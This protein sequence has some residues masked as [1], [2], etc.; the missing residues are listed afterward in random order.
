MS[1]SARLKYT[2]ARCSSEDP[3]YPVSE[4]LTHSPDT[5]GWQSARFCDFPQEL[6]LQF[7]TP[8]HLRQ[9]QFLSHQSKIAT[10]IE[11]FTALPSPGQNWRYDTA[12]FKRL[13]YF[14]LD[15]NERS[16]FQA[17]ELKSVY[18][19]VSVQFLRIL[20][21]K[22]HVNRFNIVNQVGL[23]AV[24]CLG[25]ALG[26]DLAVGPPAP[27]PVLAQRDGAPQHDGRGALGA[28]KP[29]A[30]PPAISAAES[31]EDAAQAAA[32]EMQFDARTVERLRALE[33]A[34]QRAVELEDYDEAKRLK[35]MLNKLRRTGQLIRELEERK[36]AAVQNEDFDAAKSLKVEIDRL[37]AGVD[38]P[39]Q[40]GSPSPPASAAGMPT[41]ASDGRETPS[42]HL[43]AGQDSPVGHQ[44]SAHSSLGIDR[45]PRGSRQPT[46]ATAMPSN[47]SDGEGVS[48]QGPGP[49]GRASPRA[50]FPGAP[51]SPAK[52]QGSED[53]GYVSDFRKEASNGSQQVHQPAEARPTDSMGYPSSADARAALRSKLG[54]PAEVD[55]G[56]RPRSSG[57]RASAGVPRDRGHPL[58]GVPNVD[59]LPSPEE[60]GP[61]VDKAADEIKAMFGEY[62]ARCIFSKTWNLRDAAL[63]K[64]A[65]DLRQGEHDEENV[66]ELLGAY[67]A[68]LKISLLDKNVQVFLASA[69]LLQAVCQQ[70]CDKWRSRNAEAQAALDPLLRL[71]VERLGDA[72]AR[73][74]KTTRDALLEFGRCP[75]LTTPFVAQHLLR[76]LKKKN[77]HSRVYT[78]RLQLLTALVTEAGVQPEQREG[79]PLEPTVQLAMEWFAS[80]QADVREGSVKLVAACFRHV[81]LPRIEKHLASL[82]AAQR[83]VFDIEFDKVSAA[84]ADKSELSKPASYSPPG[85]AGFRKAE[86]RVVPEEPEDADEEEDFTCQ[87]CG[88]A[89]DAFTSE[90]LDLHYFTECPMLRM[91]ELCQ[92]VIEI[93]TLQAHL[94]EEC[95]GGEEARAM[96]AKM[97][98]NHCSL[99]NAP[100]GAGDDADWQRHLLVDGC[101][102]NPRDAARTGVRK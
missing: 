66:S 59:D 33:K 14:S 25:E 43:F 92:Q 30:S 93:S 16:Q 88:R 18:V 7:E 8:V 41:D 77:V 102:Q 69:G 38:K 52:S 73:V 72:N 85:N 60:L 62:I 75:S 61:T 17:R 78:S 99:C 94:E 98:P 20:L 29:C 49:L 3:E 39:Q 83:E 37:R 82:R 56:D 2:I 45:A 35:D 63:Q 79:V 50:A 32:D 86:C 28:Q 22:C 36:K 9:V 90:G 21:H 15:N 19:D 44:Q 74:E 76:P 13:G 34:K 95:E 47:S 4:L 89:D 68:V 12:Q 55:Q 6:G 70:L 97:L 42:N 10:K 81:G 58:Q 80:P 23:V 48:P 54:S 100:L 27:N 40:P 84:V 65:L 87:F 1:A 24:N 101:P 57:S 53:A 26:P 91:C 96:A 5:K 71:L 51:R 31:A 46:M 67:A 11:L 64:L